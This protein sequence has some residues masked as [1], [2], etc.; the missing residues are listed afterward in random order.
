MKTKY[1]SASAFSLILAALAWAGEPAGATKAE[2]QGGTLTVGLGVAA[3]FSAVYPTATIP[4]RNPV[5]A[6]FRLGKGE[7]YGTLHV[8]WQALESAGIAMVARELA[9]SDLAIPK[10]NDRG[11]FR[12]AP[13][14]PLPPG[15][16]RVEVTADGKPW[17]S[18]DFRV[19]PAQSV[20]ITDPA[21]VF[22][23]AT[24]NRWTYAVT[25]ETG[26]G[27]AITDSR[28]TLGADGKYHMT[29]DLAVAGLDRA[30]AR[31]EIR[32]NGESESEE[33]FQW[34]DEGLTVTQT[35]QLGTLDVM[36]P[37]E[38]LLPW[39]LSPPKAWRYRSKDG[40]VDRSCHAFGPVPLAAIG[41]EGLGYV[42]VSMEKRPDGLESRER[43]FLPG[44]GLV[45]IIQVNASANEVEQIRADMTLTA[46]TL[47][48]GIAPTASA[49]TTPAAEVGATGVKLDVA[50]WVP[51][52]DRNYAWWGLVPA[53]QK[54]NK[55]YKSTNSS[56]TL[57]VG[58]GRYDVYWVQD[59]ETSGKPLRIAADVEVK[60]G[61]LTTV[62]LDSGVQLDVADWAPKLDANYGWWGL[63]P[64]GRP[65]RDHISWTK[66]AQQLI[67]PPGTY[68]VYRVR[69]FNTGSKPLLLASKVDVKPGQLVTVKA[70]SGV[71]LNVAKWVPVLDPNY[72]WWGL[73]PEGKTPRDRINWTNSADA[74]LASPGL[75]DVYR[76]RDFETSGKP[77]LLAGKVDVKPDQLVTVDATS[78]IA[79]KVPA[80]TPSL[81]PNYGWWGAVPTGGRPN[82]R[83]NWMKGSFAQ[84]LVLP[85]GTYDLIWQQDFNDK[86]HRVAAGVVVPANQLVEVPLASTSEEVK[87]TK[88]T[89]PGQ[90]LQTCLEAAADFTPVYPTTRFYDT[91][92]GLA[93]VFNFDKAGFAQKLTAAWIAVD[94]G[95]VAPPNTRMA[96]SS[97]S[98]G[99]RTVRGVFRYSQTNP[100]PAGKYRVEVTADGTPWLS[101]DFEVV[102]A[103]R[104]IALAAPA[105][106]LPLTSGTVWPYALTLE[107]GKGA[108]VSLP[109]V[110][111]GPDGK[112][113]AEFTMSVAGVGAPRAGEGSGIAH[114]ESRL[115][116]KLTAEEWWR[117]SAAGLEATQ[118]KMGSQ[119]L[120]L[121]P[122]QVMIPCP[123]NAPAKWTY[124][125]KDN[126]IHQT[127]RIWGP[128]PIEAPQGAAPGYVVLTDEPMGT[129]A[130]VQMTRTVERHFLPGVGITRETIIAALGGDLVSRQDILYQPPEHKPVVTLTS[131]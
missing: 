2:P 112:L 68:D 30:G 102:A 118:R 40:K 86:P 43:W 14:T 78:G 93:A 62:R 20:S 110:A 105:D 24:G 91:A 37:P 19:A 115:N 96:S 131:Y 34:S 3:D 7:S 65:G 87:L 48:R 94:V 103:P 111:P 55:R 26:K 130:G 27:T 18:A 77:L 120:V 9:G 53:G 114:I 56:D 35:R 97:L 98:L 38:L 90:S 12:F 101:A 10:G 61:Q 51:R 29:L 31:L 92:R 45:R 58:P 50:P 60:A 59:F 79:V 64:A 54:P 66:S 129:L 67:A 57:I 104:N 25:M 5:C 100:L 21:E 8:S 1:A 109:G 74:L 127:Y 63:V 6:L 75:Y 84:P 42:T 76:A 52:P 119:T 32:P 72:G 95:S 73:A 125:S 117:T 124:A 46:A 121:D 70:D 49:F 33:W 81:D 69:D 71:R 44:V 13:T 47:H 113:R 4:F 17:R 36:S 122:P 41:R 16:Y 82:A 106:L 83:V 107:G 123:L 11:W 89:V 28:L 22:P 99:D 88:I 126:S 23:L 80:G 128:F 116:G 15:S 85:P 39:P 108:K